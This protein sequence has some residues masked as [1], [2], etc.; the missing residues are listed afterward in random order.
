MRTHLIDQWHHGHVFLGEPHDHPQPP[1]TY[2]ARFAGI[3]GI[4]HV[5]IEVHPCP[6]HAPTAA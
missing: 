2:K 4:S 3:V 5:T 6:D 1:Q